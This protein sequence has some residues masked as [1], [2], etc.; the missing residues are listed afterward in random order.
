[1]WAAQGELGPGGGTGGLL[2]ALCFQ[3]A[4]GCFEEQKEKENP[5]SYSPERKK[6]RKVRSLLKHF[7]EGAF[8]AESCLKFLILE[9]SK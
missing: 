3:K 6:E 8:I 9:S 1:M 7:S 4:P 2:P 5:C